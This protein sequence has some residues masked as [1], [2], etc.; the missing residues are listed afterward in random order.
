[1]KLGTSMENLIEYRDKGWKF[2]I[3]NVRGKKYITIRRG[4]NVKSLGAYSDEIWRLIEE[5]TDG[6]A[7][8]TEVPSKRSEDSSPATKVDA[9][10]AVIGLKVVKAIKGFGVEPGEALGFIEAIYKEAKKQDLAPETV[11]KVAKGMHEMTVE[12]QR[13]YIALEEKVREKWR[14]SESLGIKVSEYEQK[15]EALSKANETVERKLAEISRLLE[16]KIELAGKVKEAEDLGLGPP[17]LTNLVETAQSI[18]ARHG[19]A[20]KESIPWLVKDLEDNWEPKLGFENEKTILV[21]ELDQLKEKI[22]LADGNEKVTREKVRAQ[23]ESLKE[24]EELKKYVSAAELIEFKNLITDSGFDIPTFRRE[25]EK[26]GSV[27]ASVD[28]VKQE[29]YAQMAR[30][31]QQVTFLSLQVSTLKAS[32]SALEAEI[33]TLNSEA[34]RGIGEAS[35]KIKEV[36]EGLKQDFEAP[37]TGYKARI[38][39]LGNEAT[40]KMNEELDTQRK[41]LIKSAGELSSFITSSV[42]EVEVLKKSTW[43]VGKLI[44]FNVH[45]TRL[46]RLVAGESVG[47]VEALSTMKMTVD[48]FTDYLTRNHLANRYPSATRFSEEL[49]SF[50]T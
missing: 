39:S 21:A 17:Q 4:K 8:E 33:N 46:A 11:V 43:D 13:D 2:S 41:T 23:E 48:A 24:L 9:S 32:K 49:R 37:E 44:G 34:I 28:H 18:G 35:K 45:L 40:T 30:L 19:L 36:A 14:L 26:L 3:K 42:S 29:S 27:T 10:E 1:M 47:T 31:E 5:I 7:K 12:G 22:K 20:I 25:V 38:Q 16:S 50:I 15:N 6:H